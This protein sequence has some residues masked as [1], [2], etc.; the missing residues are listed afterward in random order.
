MSQCSLGIIFAPYFYKLPSTFNLW[1][2]SCSY[3]KQFLFIVLTDCNWQGFVPA[4]VIIK[5]ISFPSLRKLF[6]S[7]F[8][9]HI[10]LETPYKLCD[11]KP[12]LGYIF[13]EYI[14]QKYVYWGHCDM[15]LIFGDLSKFFPKRP[16]DKIGYLG[17]LCFYKNS[18][19]ISSAFMLSS[20]N[21]ITYKD[22]FSSATH[23]AFDEAPN[24]GINALFA[25]NHKTIYPF[26]ED[27][28]DLIPT[29]EDFSISVYR[30]P[31]FITQQEK[32][33]FSFEGGKTYGY[34]LCNTQIIKKE[35][36]YIHMQKR[37]MEINI[38]QDTDQY[39][40]VPNAFVPWREI[41]SQDIINSQ[42]SSWWGRIRRLFAVKRKSL[43]MF[44]KRQ[45][46][47]KKIIINRYIRKGTNENINHG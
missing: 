17:H 33:I 14:D 32:R 25:R 11:Y 5:K 41:T 3:N 38:S 39:L 37:K 13:Q 9:F 36:A 35:Y 16:F 44:L 26:Q 20:N 4:N 46:T 27:M 34:A 31:K 19:D 12:A 2:R 18:S 23:F 42:Y 15:D 10:S 43:P 6:Q 8:D 28:A 7:K 24:Y 40:I 30:Y 21:S 47:I 29:K 1:L 45:Y 22:I